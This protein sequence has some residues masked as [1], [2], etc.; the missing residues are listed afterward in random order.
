[1]ASF[2]T[3]TKRTGLQFMIPHSRVSLFQWPRYIRSSDV[4]ASDHQSWSLAGTN[5]TVPSLWVSQYQLVLST[6]AR[7]LAEGDM[8]EV[9]RDAER[10]LFAWGVLVLSVST[11]WLWT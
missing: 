10:S 5:H 2:S 6:L 9:V 3:R 4:G 1:M 7:A 11:N 8:E